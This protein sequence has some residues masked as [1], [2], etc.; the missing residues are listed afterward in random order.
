M[1]LEKKPVILLQTEG[2]YPYSGGGISTWAQSLCRD[3]DGKIDY[4]LFTLTGTPNTT[5][6]YELPDNIKSI[7]KIPLWG[8]E[9][10]VLYY[11]SERSY[12]SHLMKKSRTTPEII[13]SYFY[14]IFMDF[15][16][17]VLEPQ[18]TRD[19]SPEIIYGMWKFFQHF[20]YKKTMTDI[21]LWEYFRDRLYFHYRDLFRE[22]QSELPRLMDITVGMRWFYHFLM[23]I[24]AS[25]P[26][27]DMT[28]SSLSGFPSIPSIVLKYEYGTPSLITEH[29]VFIR[30]R[31][32]NISNT[33]FRYFSKKMLLDLSIV[34]TSAAYQSV[35]Q[36]SPV[37]HFNTKWEQIF[38]GQEDKIKV[39]HNGIDPNYFLP[40]PKPLETRDIPTVVAV[41]HIF[42]LKDIETMIRSCA[43]V[44][45]SIPNIQYRVYGSLT[46]DVDYV[47]T[48]QNL[49]KELGLEEN[50]LL[51]GF[52]SNPQEIYN[53]GDL[54]ILTSFSEGLP[55]TVMEAMCCGRPVVTTD[56]GGVSEIVGDDGILCKPH[57]PHQIAVAVIS[58]L[59][60]NNLRI[61][62]G[63]SARERIILNFNENNTTQTYYD[64][65]MNFINRPNKPLKYNVRVES[66]NKL[67]DYLSD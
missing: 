14:P 65:Y 29:G 41:N 42:P 44:K 37:A 52:H 24:A 27:V 40:K 20:D 58:L 43:I 19:K 26:K 33:D 31:H 38:G 30:E 64:T 54:Y 34:I 53:E 8:A 18:N 67:L 32:I 15:V 7:M 13:E 48:C 55:Y 3:L 46:V 66:V 60:N 11:D 59:K 25:Y 22:Y 45:E 61:R 28:H 63:R 35:D 50:F 51:M 62:L 4:I 56:I 36:I 49:I 2:A 21:F 6:H 16:E 5:L 10:P 9:D 1:G 23:P 12:S 17:C 57:N 47:K 39:I